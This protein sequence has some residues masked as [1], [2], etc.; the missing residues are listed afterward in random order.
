LACDVGSK[1]KALGGVVS[2][3]LDF[4]RIEDWE[5]ADVLDPTMADKSS[6]V[7]LHRGILVA[8]AE[9]D[10]AF[11]SQDCRSQIGISPYLILPQAVLLHNQEILRRVAEVLPSQRKRH[12]GNL[13]SIKA[14]VDWELKQN[15]LPNIFYYWHERTLY[16]KGFIELGLDLAGTRAEQRLAEL[17]ARIEADARRR[18]RRA[19]YMVE[20]LIAILTAVFVKDLIDQALKSYPAW[21]GPAFYILLG[22][23]A[24]V[25]GVLIWRTGRS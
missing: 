21:Q 18:G 23:I 11:E 9:Q 10:R 17:T 25:F 20:G 4:D 6:L 19:D 2:G 24:I 3:L 1:L 12:A 15:M 16:E 8:V 13:E 5:L 22:A 7:C 14:T